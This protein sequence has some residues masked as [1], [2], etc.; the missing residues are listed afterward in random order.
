MCWNTVLS[1][2]LVTCSPLPQ[3]RGE[4][5]KGNRKM[6]ITVASI[7]AVLAAT[8]VIASSQP[9]TPLYTVRME[10]ASHRMN[11]LPT[12]VNEFTYTAE[13]R[14]TVH[15]AAT[16]SGGICEV[17]VG[18]TC[19]GTCI[20][21]TCPNTCPHTCAGNPTC[22][23]TCPDTCSSTCD[24]CDSTCIG[25][26]CE[27]TCEETCGGPICDTLQVSCWVIGC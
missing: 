7:C 23:S 24:T 22:S 17:T 18:K 5:M 19:E 27:S 3:L 14:Y 11:F 10:Q 1:Y 2:Y 26:T 6:L 16:G 8:T 20:E 9:H 15:Y 13:N 12:A 25:D 21:P 4:K